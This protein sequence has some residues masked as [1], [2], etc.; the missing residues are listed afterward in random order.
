VS[1]TNRRQAEIRV[2]KAEG[3]LE[4]ADYPAD[5]RYTD[6]QAVATIALTHAVLAVADAIK[7]AAP[8]SELL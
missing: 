2:A 6:A 1:E 4:R 7:D 8:L 3:I 5:D